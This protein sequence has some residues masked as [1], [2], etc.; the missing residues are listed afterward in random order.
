MEWFIKLHRQ[1]LSWEWYDDI[2]TKV[3]FIHLLLKVN[4]KDWKRRWQEIKR[5]QTLT[6]LH[7]LSQE[8]WLSIQKIRTSIKK[9]KSTNEITI[10]ATKNFSII[11]MLNYNTYQDSNTQDN[12]APTK[13]QQTN[14][15]QSTTNNNEKNKKN[16]KKKDTK[17]SLVEDFKNSKLWKELQEE[18]YID[19]DGELYLSNDN[20]IKRLLDFIKFRKEIKKPLTLRAV[21][22]VLM[23]GEK[24]DLD[25]FSQMIDQSILNWWQWIFELKATDSKNINQQ[26]VDY[27]KV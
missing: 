17:V 9:L 5:W 23:Q 26:G 6:W 22:L 10:K 19:K 16:E 11:E 27:T 3:L 13:K 18:K 4:H 21:E 7:V 24:F 12:K 2:N 1:L 8:T 20:F 25:I 15:K 14:N